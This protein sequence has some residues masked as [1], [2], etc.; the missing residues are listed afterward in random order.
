MTPSTGAVLEFCVAESHQPDYPIFGIS[1]K[2]LF[3]IHTAFAALEPDTFFISI[4]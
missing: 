2:F 3:F 1:R 4:C